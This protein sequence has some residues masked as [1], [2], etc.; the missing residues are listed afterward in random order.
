MDVTG[1]TWM[2]LGFGT[3]TYIT[4]HNR[5]TY[6]TGITYRIVADLNNNYMYAKRL[7]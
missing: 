5:A 3:E 6:L 4:T 2:H 7:H 1:E